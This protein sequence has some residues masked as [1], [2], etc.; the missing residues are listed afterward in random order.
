[1]P[2][3]LLGQ[4]GKHSCSSRGSTAHA[5]IPAAAVEA[6]AKS[7]Y[8]AARHDDEL[9]QHWRCFVGPRCCCA[10]TAWVLAW[11]CCVDEAGGD[12]SSAKTR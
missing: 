8:I 9:M 4:R 10:L 3:V 7:A 6:A 2:A 12:Y 11:H 1:M 5:A